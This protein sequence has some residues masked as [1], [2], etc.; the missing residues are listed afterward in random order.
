MCVPG[1]K[2]SK[3]TTQKKT[4]LHRKPQ[5]SAASLRPSW[6]T[7][8]CKAVLPCACLNRPRGFSSP[9]CQAALV[10]QRWAIHHIAVCVC[11]CT[12]PF[13]I[14]L[15]AVEVA[16]AKQRASRLCLE[17]RRYNTGASPEHRPPGSHCEMSKVFWT[18][19]VKVFFFFNRLHRPGASRT[20]PSA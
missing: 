19:C 18:T 2:Y 4:T 14:G 6:R 11:V 16:R 15:C 9:R 17:P 12:W 10:S 8:S 5:H 7:E 3:R 20:T 1:K 13:L